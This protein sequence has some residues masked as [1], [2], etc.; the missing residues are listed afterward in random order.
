[1]RALEIQVRHAGL[2]GRKAFSLIEV[3]VATAVL[4]LVVVLLVQIIGLSTE[5]I[6]RSKRKLDAAGQAR[7][8]LDRLGMDLSS[9]IAR[10]D[11]P[12]DFSSGPGNDGLRFYT[13][14]SGYQGQR[15]V[16]LVS[17]RIHEGAGDRAYQAE[18]SAA[19]TDWAQVKALPFGETNTPV[20]VDSDYEVLADGVFR[21]EIS[22][23]KKSDGQLTNIQPPL[24]DIA[25]IVVAVAALDE[26]SR[27]ILA[28][29]DLKKLADKLP[30]A[31]ENK[32]PITAW[33]QTISQPDFASDIN[34]L[35]ATQ[36]IDIYQR[37]FPLP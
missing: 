24:K 15:R 35:K 23:V 18:R 29:G 17:F 22:Y 6:G 16:S 4:S 36:S 31:G 3:L 12:M 5:A 19:G 8:F 11:L 30:D 26:N 37:Y 7:L 10:A 25:A 13:E 32:D 21:M 27:K 33:R 2:S 28:S 1:M 34:K 14:V 9:R 20:P